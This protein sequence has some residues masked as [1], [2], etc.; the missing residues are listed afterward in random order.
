MD[1]RQVID[2]LRSSLEHITAEDELLGV[3]ADRLTALRRS[4]PSHRSSF[5]PSDIEFLKSLGG[6]S[7]HL[8]AF[9]E[10]KEELASV[11]SLKEYEDM[12]SR[13]TRAKD[14]LACFP[15]A[16]RIAKE[17]RGLNERLPAI[18]EQDEGQRQFR[19][20]ARILDLQRNPRLCRCHHPM[21]IRKGTHG[22]FW[23]CSRYPFCSATAQLTPEENALLT[24]S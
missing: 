16:R 2:D 8:R 11:N 12:V 10:L 9:I 21:V 13:L 5:T 3:I 14:S 20:N 15:V 1:V 4:Y 23:G 19:L 6:I 22:H 17:I 18:R 24:S 7:D